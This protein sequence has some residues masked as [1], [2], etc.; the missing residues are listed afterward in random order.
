MIQY[1]K[2]E[3]YPVRRIMKGFRVTCSVTVQNCNWYSL[4]GLGYG[5]EYATW[6]GLTHGN[7]E[8]HFIG[9]SNQRTLEITRYKITSQ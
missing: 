3:D 9:E 4:F 7:W 5:F 8:F 1:G 6:I 2:F